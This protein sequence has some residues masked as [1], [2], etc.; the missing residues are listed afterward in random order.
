MMIPIRRAVLLGASSALL[1]YGASIASAQTAD[2]SSVP[3]P[4]ARSD[5]APLDQGDIVVTATR[6]A[7]RLAYT[8]A[9]DAG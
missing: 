2:S 4:P 1:P 9:P 7:E 5:L 8:F 3:S 6:Q